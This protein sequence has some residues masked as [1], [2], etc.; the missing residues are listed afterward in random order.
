MIIRVLMR[1]P[2]KPCHPVAT[3][4]GGIYVTLKWTKP[5]H[6]NGLDIT[7]YV[8]KYGRKYTDVDDYDE[9]CVSGD[10]TNF[11]FTHQLNA[12]TLYRFSV[13]AV[14]DAGRGEFSEFTNYVETSL[15]EHYN[16]HPSSV[17]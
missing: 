16:Y 5:E 4:I 9:L 14:N 12:F 2:S 7:G 10:T 6:K 1:V 8:I 13:A 15:G 3:H 17:Q 11:Q